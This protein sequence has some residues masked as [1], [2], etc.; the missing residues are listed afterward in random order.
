MRFL[1][2]TALTEFWDESQPLLL[3]GSWCLRVDRRHEWERFQY[4]V[5]PSPW[6]DRERF[7]AATEYL[8]DCG[9]R[10]LALLG[11]YLN[12]VH[13][14]THGRR[15]WR[16]LIGPWLLHFLHSAYDRYVHLR[17]AFDRYPDIRTVILASQS[18]RVPRDSVEALEYLCDDPYN[19]Q[20][21][22]QLLQVLGYSFPARPAKAEWSRWSVLGRRRGIRYYL[23]RA[24]NAMNRSV[25]LLPAVLHR[26]VLPM[27]LYN[28]GLQS[29]EILDLVLR[30]RFRAAPI[31]VCED[32][33]FSIPEAK[34]DEHRLDLGS[35]PGGDEFERT[36]VRLLPEALPSLYLEGYHLASTEALRGQR[37]MPRVIISATDWYFNELFKYGAAQAS[38]S[39]SRLVAVQHGGG[40]GIFRFSAA[41]RHEARLSDSYLVW[42]W[43]SGNSSSFWNAPSPRLSELLGGGN[44]V[45]RSPKGED[46]LLITTAHPRYLYR[47]HST[48]VGSQWA[49]YFEWQLRFLGS[50]SDELRHRV[51]FRPYPVD[52]GHGIR[53]R[54]SREFPDLV[55]DT[56]KPST[57]RLKRARIVVIDHN[58]TSH[59]E[60]L[61]GNIPTVIFW[62]PQCWEERRE[63]APYLNDLRKVGILLDSPE[64]AAAQVSTVYNDLLS[65]W[66][67]ENVQQARRSFADRYALARKDWRSQWVKILDDELTA[68]KSP[69]VANIV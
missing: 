57:E 29:S 3:L 42:G 68:G 39:G 56:G 10:L 64:D 46:I 16:I 40:Y 65:W 33:S 4:T 25:A 44:A 8:D 9:E 24:K 21:I 11:D 55:C 61:A 43:A 62:D 36:F 30:T 63:A 51:I 34:F 52:Y 49:N 41:E 7:Y 54:I 60:T 32:W 19:L 27:G 48:P 45:G 13:G 14:V 38:E 12:S 26:G 59:L 28:V 47:F 50:L 17:E 15:Y 6:N 37:V 67:N 23:G 31:K 2:T 1:G 18:F 53:E 35:L 20:I 22:S 5:M 69:A 58:S 66:N